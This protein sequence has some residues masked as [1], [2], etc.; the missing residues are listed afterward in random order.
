MSVC[1][2]N[3]KE[4]VVQTFNV[5]INALHALKNGVSK[6]DI[7]K[8]LNVHVRT[9]QK[10]QKNQKK[11]LDNE[12]NAEE[13]MSRK[14]K[15]NRKLKFDII[16][17]LSWLW[18]NES[19]NAGVPINGPQI[20]TQAQSMYIALGGTE[21]EFKASNGWLERFKRRHN[22]RSMTRLGEKQSSNADAAEK[23]V[24][25][26]ED[27]V[28]EENLCEHQV[29]N[30]DETGLNFRNMP[31]KTFIP[32]QETSTS[33]FK[34]MKE[35]ITI[36]A[37][38]NASGGLKIPL[39]VIG[40]STEPVCMKNITQLP[41]HYKS[42]ECAWMVSS[43]FKEWFFTEFVPKVTLYLKSKK[44][45]IKAVLLV[46]NCSSHPQKLQIGTNIKVIFLPPNTSALIQ[47]M[48]QGVL[49]YL[50]LKY[51]FLMMEHII[52][53]VNNGKELMKI[54][55]NISLGKAVEWLSIAWNNVR[56][57]TIKKSWNSLWPRNCDATAMHNPVLGLMNSFKN[58]KLSRSFHRILQ[59]TE[60]YQQISY[61]SVLDW[62]NPPTI[63]TPEEA[64]S[65]EEIMQVIAEEE[66]E[67]ENAHNDSDYDSDPS[68][69]NVDVGDHL[70]EVLAYCKKHPDHFS[71][72]E[73][74]ILL[75]INT[76]ILNK[77]EHIVTQQLV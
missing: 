30:C 26:F 53:N 46:D 7:A 32:E 1:K 65:N 4:H 13:R 45:P 22:I 47:P 18:F 51:R 44:L 12:Y 57:V 70:K 16:D 9:V 76:R 36:M 25:W 73:I 58:K 42:Q 40:R 68:I 23:F 59:N 69:S 8:Q 67:K 20:C 17:E 49:Q 39:V 28:R 64:L 41:V 31:K 38:S 61:D 11:I 27:Y 37:S 3:R 77:T 75:R 21:Y 50:K 56:P 48:D 19:R 10:W 2:R 15:R 54:V 55:E 62:L 34:E 29:F 52:N 33:G 14:I 74:F 63:L 72:D 6:T 24:T 71:K 43:L 60:S 5:K 35:R 66:R